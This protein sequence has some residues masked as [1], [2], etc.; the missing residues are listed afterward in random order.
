MISTLAGGVVTTTL[1]SL[2]QP[3][4]FRWPQLHEMRGTLKTS[5]EIM[6]ASVAWYVSQSADFFVA[7]KVLGR[8][9]L[10]NYT[11]AW[12]LAYSIVD[13]VTS[14]VNGVTSSI[15]SAS[16]H[17]RALLTRYITRIMGA[18]ALILLPATTGVALVSRELVL[19]VVG[20]KR[21]RRSCRSVSSC[22][23][24]VYAR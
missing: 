6:I 1:A 16:K 5:R 2:W 12:S 23:T 17:D 21:R 13:K 3:L 11:F 9:A 10:G 19:A 24:R 7:G 14:C 8:A 20:A 15:F 22:C 4:G 18:L